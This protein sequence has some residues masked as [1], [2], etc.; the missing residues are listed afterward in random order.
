MK[1]A[2]FGRALPMLAC[3]AIVASAPVF[4]VDEPEELVDRRSPLVIDFIDGA[5]LPAA[6]GIVVTGTHG[7]LGI[8]KVNGGQAELTK[9]KD[10]PL[11]DFTALERLSDSQVLLGNSLGH[12][13]LFDG[14]TVTDVGRLSEYDEPVLDIAVHNGQAWAVGGR[15]MLAKSADGR[16]FEPVVVS[17]T[18]QPVVTMPGTTMGDWYFGA[19][20]ISPDTVQF[21]G[22]VGG[23]PAVPDQDYTLYPDEGF[24]Q[25][26]K[27]LDAEP[28]PTISF[29]FQPGPAFRPGDVSWNV[30]LF[31][32][33]GVTIAGEFG[34][35]LQSSDGGASWTRR[36][37]VIT[38]K[39]PEPP[40]WIAGVK[41]DQTLY[42][43][44]AAGVIHASMDG[45]ENWQPIPAPG[46]EGV[47]GVTL[48]PSGQP[49]IAGAVGLI[50]ILGDN[51]EWAL[52]DRTELQL[53]SWLRTPVEMPDGSL[54]MLGG[55]STV[56]V[57]RDNKWT[58][59]PVTVKE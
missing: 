17:D 30:V 49:A 32:D 26:M 53:L 55:R 27:D 22:S 58:R 5:Y 39:E 47:F 45:G 56:I 37:T 46:A 44:G 25:F 38:N 36:D 12:V 42:L 8:L 15:G 6:E 18:T 14:K 29:K 28:L 11:V 57:Y 7:L 54:V 31:D 23:Q 21:T 43:T 20:N 13:F 50:G 3:G 19:S 34:M 51:K 40:Y 16:K 35:I 10:V 1:K 2:F 4:A 52:A 24:I 9:L 41:R 48:L 33:S 59:I